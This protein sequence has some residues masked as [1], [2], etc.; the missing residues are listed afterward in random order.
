MIGIETLLTA[1]MAFVSFVGFLIGVFVTV[2][3]GLAQ[4]SP[5][6]FRSVD[7]REGP[8]WLLQIRRCEAMATE[9]EALGFEEIGIKAEYEGYARLSSRVFYSTEHQTYASLHSRLLRSE[10]FLTSSLPNRTILMGT[11]LV[12]E[13]RGSAQLQAYKARGTLS[14]RLAQ[15]R[16]QITRITGWT[17]GSWPAEPPHAGTMDTLIELDRLALR[18]R[19]IHDRVDGEPH[20]LEMMPGSV[21]VRVEHQG[22]AI[23]LRKTRTSVPL[24]LPLVAFAG[25]FVMD[26]LGMEPAE[27]L[28]LVA[29]PP[30][31]LLA[32]KNYFWP[33]LEERRVV[34]SHQFLRVGSKAFRLSDV[35]FTI[36]KGALVVTDR[37]T[38]QDHRFGGFGTA[39]ELY[40]LLDVL[41]S[42]RREDLIDDGEPESEPPPELAD[43]MGRARAAKQVKQRR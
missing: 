5:H 40:W 29:V 10:V 18:I 20:P 37:S 41:E 7:E 6:R 13:W 43:L 22:I 35:T 25:A 38:G 8:T 3:A 12:Q 21:T 34:V 17:D 33:S 39:T 15:H 2:N 19:Y 14:E 26:W 30:L 31:L 28:L 24:L 27:T 4:L 36:S 16:E 1:F 23:G 42:A 32:M 9:L 11:D